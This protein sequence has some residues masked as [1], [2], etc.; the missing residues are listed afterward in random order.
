MCYGILHYSSVARKSLM[1]SISTQTYLNFQLKKKHNQHTKCQNF[2]SEIHIYIYIH[3]ALQENIMNVYSVSL[4][5]PFLVISLV[6]FFGDDVPEL[7][8]DHVLP[9][10]AFLATEHCQGPLL[11]SR[12]NLVFLSQSHGLHPSVTGTCNKLTIK[13]INC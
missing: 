12:I 4:L 1:S 2:Q 5:W 10:L 11:V 8:E 13:G 7:S 3:A 9:L 6:D